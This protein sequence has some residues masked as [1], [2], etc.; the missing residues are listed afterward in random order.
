M[1]SAQAA[2]RPPKRKMSRL[3]RREAIDGYL[4]ISPWLIGFTLFIIGM[5][6]LKCAGPA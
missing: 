4:F 5:S 3:A 6:S 1:L 2:A